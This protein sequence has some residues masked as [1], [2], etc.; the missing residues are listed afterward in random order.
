VKTILRVAREGGPLKVV[1]DQTG[2]PTWAKNIAGVIRTL[3]QQRADGTYHYTDAGMT[4]WHGFASAILAGASE[5]GFTLKTNA[6]EA[7]PTSGYPTPAKRPPYSVLDTG[8]IQPLLAEPIPH[9]CDSLNK[10]LKELKACADC[11]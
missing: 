11:W 2:S 10:M 4:S 3:V 5:A 1:N 8:K 7:I 6:V 9:W